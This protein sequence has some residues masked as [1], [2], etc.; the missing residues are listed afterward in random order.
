MAEAVTLPAPNLPKFPLARYL[1]LQPDAVLDR[2]IL[3]APQSVA[4]AAGSS[5]VQR[6]T[7]VTSLDA[8]LLAHPQGATTID[9]PAHF[10]SGDEPIVLTGPKQA[11]GLLYVHVGK[12]AKVTIQEKWASGGNV[13]GV[14]LVLVIDADAEVSWL[15]YDSFTAETVI[16]N[17]T[18]TL[19][20]NAKLNWTLAGFSRN[21]G[22]NRVDVRLLG[23]NAEATVNVGVLA[24]G[25]QHVSYTT[26]VTNE[27]QHTVGH[28]NQRGVIT[29]SAH[30]VFNGIGHIIKGARGSDAQQENRVLMLSPHAEGDAN[31]ILLI[32]EN[33]V[34][35]GHAASVTRVNAD[36][37]YYLMS[38]GLSATLAKRLVIRGFLE[39]GLAE[40]DDVRLKKELFATID[41][42]LVAEDA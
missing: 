16:A 15:S 28:I 30:L 32:D 41:R 6:F 19:G 1:K 24:A 26:S 37:L 8:W 3:H 40:I 7:P 33:D 35:A 9:I 17:R 14:W 2:V 39:G 38:R 21:S 25:S 29:G 22:L 42:T 12:G 36:Q 31:P 18:A 20:A 5:E 13:L 10:V 27:A 4:Y 23:Q 11:G 34:T